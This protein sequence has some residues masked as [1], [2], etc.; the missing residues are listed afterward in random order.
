MTIVFAKKTSLNIERYNQMM[1]SLPS[2]TQLGNARRKATVSY[3][4]HNKEIMICKIANEQAA[5]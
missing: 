2:G 1:P 3:A 5:E 4:N